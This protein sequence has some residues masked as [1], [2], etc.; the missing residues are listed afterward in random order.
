[1]ETIAVNE[2]TK[3]IDELVDRAVESDR[4]ILLK[5]EKGNAIL[6]SEKDWNALQE[7]L[8]LQSIP[9]MT[10]SI[11]QGGNTSLKDCVE[12][13]IVRGILNG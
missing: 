11:K 1:M 2:D 3:K 5:G 8:Y 7:T 6:I 9:E 13:S 4:P 12:E 10:K